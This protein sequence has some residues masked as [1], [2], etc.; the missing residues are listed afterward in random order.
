M[1]VTFCTN[2]LGVRERWLIIFCDNHDYDHHH[3]CDWLR[4]YNIHHSV[5]KVCGGWGNVIILIIIMV[6]IIIIIMIMMKITIKNE[7]YLE[8]MRGSWGRGRKPRGL[9]EDTCEPNLQ[10]WVVFFYN[11]YDDISCLC[12]HTN[13]ISIIIVDLTMISH[14]SYWSCAQGTSMI[15]MHWWFIWQLW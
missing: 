1:R 12:Y 3:C 10:W 14:W 6:I 9:R 15:C 13:H 5:W 11:Y 2:E 8:G 7:K 4:F